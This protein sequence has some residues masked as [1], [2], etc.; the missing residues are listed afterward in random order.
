MYFELSEIL[1]QNLAQ[2]FHDPRIPFTGGFFTDDI[3]T[4]LKGRSEGDSP[5][6]GGTG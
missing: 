3:L 2:K 4:D 6:S 1:D 5:H